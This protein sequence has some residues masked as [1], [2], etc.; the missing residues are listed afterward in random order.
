MFDLNS[1]C[2]IFKIKPAL[3]MDFS[4]ECLNLS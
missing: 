4:G 1:I 3:L 2:G